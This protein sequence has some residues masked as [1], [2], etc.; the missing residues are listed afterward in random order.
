MGWPK[1]AVA[2]IGI[3]IFVEGS[4]WADCSEY[5]QVVSLSQGGIP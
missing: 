5:N 4:E 3:V 2:S 1:L